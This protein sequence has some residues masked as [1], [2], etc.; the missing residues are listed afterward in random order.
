MD[1]REILRVYKGA[2]KL[3]GTLSRIINIYK[4]TINILYITN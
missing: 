1:L 3:F 4:I 2:I